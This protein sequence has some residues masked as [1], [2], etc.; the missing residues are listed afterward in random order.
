MGKILTEISEGE[1][2]DKI[3]ILEIKLKEIQ[4]K[5]LIKEVEKEYQILLK[6]KNENINSDK[7]IDDLYEK[8]KNVNEEIWSIENIKRD[9]ERN[10]KFGEKFI[11]ISR[12]EYI[13]ND[14]RAKIKSDINHILNSNIK[15]IKQH[16]LK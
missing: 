8:L 6:I 9:C 12:K 5:A 10:N 11:E 4:N 7:S 2:L 14:K 1:L 13:A 15:E 3:S 16:I